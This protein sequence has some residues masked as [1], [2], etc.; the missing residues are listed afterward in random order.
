MKA[1][2]RALLTGILDYAGL[3]PPA[4]LPLEQAIRNYARFRNEPEAWMLGRFV[5]PAARLAELSPFVQEFFAVGTPL[6]VSALG[7]G[8][9]ARTDFHAGL[10]ADLRDVSAFR[11]RHGGRVALEVLETRLPPDGLPPVVPDRA[12]RLMLDEAVAAIDAVGGLTLF[13]E[14]P[15]GP[16]WCEAAA[17]LFSA[18]IALNARREVESETLPRVGFKLRCGGLEA[19][20][21]PP[22]R[23][24]ARALASGVPLK[25]TAG[26][27]HPL[28][29][30]DAV[31]DM[32]M[33]GFINV[34]A[35]GVLAHVHPLGAGTVEAVLLD[36]APANFVFDDDGLRWG[37]WH[38]TTDEV[39][40]ARRHAVLSFGSCSFDEPRED[41]RALGW[42]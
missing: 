30:R 35:A 22:A 36:V 5:C 17:V 24:I 26:L 37:D 23:H 7:R 27:H 40:A 21:F 9:N 4:K 34:F 13:T 28:R 33:H 14:V 16:H 29:Q 8:G 10:E 25:A 31:L 11:E 6:A 1:S 18:L 38:V 41:L 12:T 3:F 20:A 39:R 19:S 2:L 42:L 32:T 15:A